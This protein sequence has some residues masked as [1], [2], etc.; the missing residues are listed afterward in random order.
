MA[1]CVLGASRSASA[2][3]VSLTFDFNSL[4][5]G[6]TNTAI[7]TYMQG[8]LGGYG[9]VVSV[10]AGATT[11]KTYNGDGHVTGPGSTSVTSLTLGTSDGSTQHLT[12]YDT[13][14][15]NISTYSGFSLVFSGLAIDSVSFDYE[16]FPDGTCAALNST[17]CGGAA[18]GGIYPNQPDLTFSTNLGTVF[19][20]Y[21]KTPGTG[22]TASP[23]TE[24]PCT[25]GST[26]TTGSQCVGTTEAAPQLIGTASLLTTN[27]VGASTFNFIDWPATIGIDNFTIN[28]H[29]PPVGTSAVPEP[30]S[31]L[32]LGTGLVAIARRRKR[33][34]A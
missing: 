32:L 23:Y 7:K 24:S 21:S 26:L 34:R 12:T 4:G 14:L 15:K 8:V 9:T 18:V 11:D 27:V 17:N 16:I 6:A 1:L 2:G 5:S 25:D 33:N 13:F 31:M 20:Y 22:G 30:A 3:A 19:H 10:S 29:T 28:F